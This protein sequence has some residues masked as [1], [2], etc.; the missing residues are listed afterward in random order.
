MAELKLRV[1]LDTSYLKGQISRLPLE[2]AGANVSIRTKFDRQTIVN[3]FRLLNRYIGGKT[4]DVKIESTTL[5]NLSAKVKNFQERLTE[6]KGVN[7][8]VGVGVVQSLSPRDAGRIRSGLRTAVL[9]GSKKILIPTTIT[10]KITGKDVDAFKAAVKEKLSG[11]SVDVKANVKGGG[12]ATGLPPDF[13]KYMAEQG[14]LGKTASG[15]TMRMGKDGG[16]IKQQLNDA[17][18]SAEK[19]KSIFDGVAQSIATT[20][21]SIANIQ[22]KRLGLANVPLMAGAME[23]KIER[24]ASAIEGTESFDA[25]KSLYPEINKTIVSL[26]ALRGQVQQNTSKLSGFSLIIGLAAFAGVPLAKSIV[27]LTGSAGKFSKLL[28]KLGPNLEAAFTKAAFNIL[29]TASSRLLTGSSAA[30]LL[31]PAAEPAG[32]LPPAYRGIGPSR[33]AGALPPAY[34]G[35]GPSAEPAGLLPEYT[36]R[37]A[38]DEIIRKLGEGGKGGSLVP[39]STSDAQIQPVNVREIFD[40]R[41]FQFATLRFFRVIGNALESASNQ[42]K[43]ARIDQSVDAL[44]QS[45]DDAAKVAQAR[46]RNVSS[47]L[48]G[49]VDVRN[50]GRSNLLRGVSPVGLLPPVARFGEGRTASPYSTGPRQR[51]GETQEE[52]FARREREARMRSAVRGLSVSSEKGLRLPGTTFMGDAF[53]SGGGL[54]RVTG[55]GRSPQRGGAI[56]PYAPS[57]KLPSGYFESVNKYSQALNLGRAATDNFRASQIPFLGGLKN[58]A[59]EFG[60]ATKQVLLY[61]TA[62]KG[63]AFVTSIPGQILNAVKSQQ[64]FNNA[65]QVATQTSGSY[66]KELLFVDNVQRA[67]GLDLETTRS[68]FTRLYASM[69]PA[70]F[71]SGSIEKLFVG[72]SSAM[73][74]L[75]LTPDKAERVIYAFGQMASKGQVMSEELKGQLGDVL[76]GALAIF[77]SAAGKSI[78]EFNKEIEDGVYSGAKF[79]DLMSKVTEELITRF[80]SGAAA[81]GRSL[82]GLI[83]IV[84][85]D[86]TRTLESFAPLANS[87][88]EAILKPLGGALRQLSV[89][90]KLATGERGRVGGQVTKQE[91]VVQ[92]LGTIA[93]AERG[94]PNE[95]KALEQYKGAAQSLEALNIQLENLNELAKDPAIAQQAEDIKAFTDEIGKAA[96]FVKNFATAVGGVLSPVLN[97]LGTNLTSVIATVATLVFTFQGA[98]LGLL[99]FA[100]VMTVVKGVTAA[101]GFLALVQQVG[102][103]TAALATSGTI[104][105]TVA[106]I[107]TSLGIGARAGAAGIVLATGAT[108]SFKAAIIALMSATGL[109]LLI[110]VIGTVGAAF[111][112]MGDNAKQAAEDAKQAAKDMAEAARTGNV[113]QV[114]AAIRQA[115]ASQELIKEGKSIVKRGQIGVPLETLDRRTLSENDKAILQGLGLSLPDGAIYRKD[116]LEQINKLEAINNGVLKGASARLALAKKQQKRI[117]LGVPDIGLQGTEKAEDPNAEKAAQRGKAL[118]DA[119]EQREEAIAKA[120]EQREDDIAKVRKDAI[121]RAQKLEETFAKQRLDVERKIAQ[122]RRDLAAARED[123]NFSSRLR[124]ARLAGEDTGAIEAE[125]RAAQ[126]GRVRDEEKLQVEQ[127]ILDDQIDRAKQIEKLKKET[128][129]GINEANTRYTKTIGE[130]QKGYARSVAKIIE[131][132]SEKAG[133]RLAKAAQMVSLYMQ[134]G[135][136]NNM[137]AGATGFVIPERTNGVYNFGAQGGRSRE[138]VKTDPTFR[139]LPTSVDNLL[140]IDDKLDQLKKDLNMSRRPDIGQ[141]FTALLGAEG[142]YEDVAMTRG[143]AAIIIKKLEEAAVQKNITPDAFTAALYDIGEFATSPDA[144]RRTIRNLMATPGAGLAVRSPALLRNL[145]TRQLSQ[146]QANIKDSGV[147]PASLKKQIE[148]MLAIVSQLQKDNLLR[149]N[150]TRDETRE[151]IQKPM[152]AAL[153]DWVKAN[154]NNTQLQEILKRS[155][156]GANAETYGVK[157]LLPLAAGFK[158]ASF[159]VGLTPAALKADQEA[160]ARERYE[161][162]PAGRAAKAAEE[163]YARQQRE[164][165]KQL[166]KKFGRQ[167]A[168]DVPEGFDTAK[169]ATDFGT[170]AAASILRG[171]LDVSRV[172]DTSGSAQIAQAHNVR[173]G[174]RVG[175]YDRPTSPQVDRPSASTTTQLQ[176]TAGEVDKLG[177]S[178]KDVSGN[179]SDTNFFKTYTDELE[180]ATQGLA[181][182]RKQAEDDVNK[183]NRVLSLRR[184]GLTGDQAERLD[185][186]NELSRKALRDATAEYQSKLKEAEGD[187]ELQQQITNEFN[188]TAEEIKQSYINLVQFNEALNNMPVELGLTFAIQD[189]KDK[190]RD[191]LDPVNQI[192]GAAGAVGDAFGE[193]FKGVITGSM[194]AQEA[195]ASFFQNTAN[196]FADMVAQ[197]IAEYLKMQLIEGIM[198]IIGGAA[199]ALGG[200]LSSGFN[201]GTSSAIDTGAT[202]WANSFATP[203]KFANGGI[204]PGGFTAFANGGVVTGPTLGL[205]G[206]GKYNEA[207]IP[208]PDGKSV[209][210]QLSGGDG[211]NQINTNITVNVSNGQAQSNATGSNSSELGRKI[212]GAVKQ[213]IVGELRPGG[214]LASR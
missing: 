46:V 98:R 61:G 173:V 59:G 193:A 28:D 201:A 187:P 6:L 176:N 10:P 170:I 83:N 204:T 114:E 180:R 154:L 185:E 150:V 87:A 67:F 9:G 205:V 20:G 43:N 111:L 29:N 158:P 213:V 62:Y 79:R 76:P 25:L 66:A 184:G 21:K 86:F 117:G 189:I 57:T 211:G 143:Q 147:N 132:G 91:Q 71:D 44:M 103:F 58:I 212:E 164:F 55:T 121:E 166:D 115:S 84:K 41:E 88:A 33:N 13:M 80:G 199:G 96:T 214:L 74:S 145:A 92:E 89:A 75:Q 4:F 36:S 157:G 188:N 162:T 168:A 206:E 60:E 97:F 186:A 47:L 53:T 152:Y 163:E 22:G 95:A 63:L 159:G 178:L 120:R 165:R 45:I 94:G 131:E 31:P 167:S 160:K 208:L 140:R 148:P 127:Q 14:L 134:R 174:N 126:A 51:I 139:D 18:G 50:L 138:Q 70:G 100:G 93:A 12:A 179:L 73:A 69:S 118:L 99:A 109:G 30:R 54:D 52:L 42:A 156:M 8:E 38:R 182:A 153:L 35:I 144:S 68:G 142:G 172:P 195:L 135:T 64:Q 105:K 116:L 49:K 90:T 7:I 125:Q 27:K 107:Y 48:S 146:G 203:L 202:G 197:M 19:I 104:G 171:V 210:V 155:L 151:K 183:L 16:D 106:A 56:V 108:I 209:P 161:A 141:Q 34:R 24:S 136:Q 1:S 23:K 137:I 11:I 3:E 65:M 133:K 192:K 194:T 175:Y 37:G 191:L 77:A 39:T 26:A 128:A 5:E 124:T 78:K 149:K 207:V 122:A 181:G 17:V 102:S 112:A 119:I 198:N 81:A 177:T 101:I 196:Y 190:L 85:G 123:V 2:F 15:M 82:Q 200:G 113:P 169:V 129:D 130:A 32:L 40:A 110:A 72:I